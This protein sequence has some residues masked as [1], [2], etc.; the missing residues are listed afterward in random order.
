MRRLHV[1]LTL[2]FLCSVAAVVVLC[3]RSANAT[4]CEGCT[5]TTV[6]KGTNTGDDCPVCISCYWCTEPPQCGGEKLFFYNALV[7]SVD[8]GTSKITTTPIPCWVKRQ[9][10]N[11]TYAPNA[12]CNGMMCAPPESG[13]CMY[14]SFNAGTVSNWPHC[15]IVGTC[16]EE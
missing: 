8:S 9:C 12:Q 11:S 7:D 16:T 6:C 15:S 14:C 13:H 1:L 3:V 2:T 5:P 4:G 10:G